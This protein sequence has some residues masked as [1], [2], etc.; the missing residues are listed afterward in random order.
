MKVLTKPTWLIHQVVGEDYV[1]YHTH[2]L[3]EY[4]SLEL[5]IKLPIPTKLAGLIINEIGLKIANGKRCRSNDII[6]GV[7]NV[8]LVIIKTKEYHPDDDVNKDDVLRII[9]PDQN[10]RYPW[11]IGCDPIYEKQV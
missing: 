10:L 11:D 7:V 8:D 6:S 9:I 4:G 3:K 5:E 1:K 2:G